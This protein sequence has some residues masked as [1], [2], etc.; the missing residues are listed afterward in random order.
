VLDACGRAAAQRLAGLNRHTAW[1]SP[2]ARFVGTAAEL[3]ELL[4]EVLAWADGVRL[5]PAVLDKDLEELSRLVLPEL[6][7]R[8][9]LAPNTADATFREQLGLA[10]PTSRYAAITAGTTAPGA[11]N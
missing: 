6:R 4:T 9:L 5:H 3:T 8:G 2:R 1:Q 7:Q 11:E 10:R